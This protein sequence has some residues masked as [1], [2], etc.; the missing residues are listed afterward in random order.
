MKNNN[1]SYGDLVKKV[2]R[3]TEK[4]GGKFQLN[5]SKFCKLHMVSNLANKVADEIECDQMEA[6]VDEQMKCLSIEF[7]CVCVY[8]KDIVSANL[9]K[10]AKLVD[11]VVFSTTKEHDLR[12][13]F[14][15]NELWESC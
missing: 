9:F 10:L 1:L 4:F 2:D 8:I 14:V 15:I 12:I 11:S 5:E 13:N 6:L 3:S 7:V